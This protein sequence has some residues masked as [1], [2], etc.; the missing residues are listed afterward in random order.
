MSVNKTVTKKIALS[1]LVIFVLFMIPKPAFAAL[2]CDLSSTQY[3]E[4]VLPLPS[5]IICPVL[6]LV[7]LALMLSG[8]VLAVLI[9]FGAIKLASSLGDP[10]GYEGAT[11]TLL[12][13]IIGFFVVV[14]SFS[15][16]MILNRTLGL[17]LEYDSANSIT[18]KV[19]LW[20]EAFL[21]GFLNVSE[22][23]SI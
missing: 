8:V 1:L 23:A 19:Q 16:L 14:G 6:R 2:N 17:G 15:I 13:A 20:W 22:D 12:F 7:N 10:K 5:Q 21:R 18:D 11:R 4:V 3:G 9:G